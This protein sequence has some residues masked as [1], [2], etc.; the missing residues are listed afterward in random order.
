MAAHFVERLIAP[1]PAGDSAPDGRYSESR[2]LTVDDCGRPV[3]TRAAGP[4]ATAMTKDIETKT[5]SDR[6][7]EELVDIE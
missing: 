7:P 3:V 1:A 6:G 5:L 4:L 2:T